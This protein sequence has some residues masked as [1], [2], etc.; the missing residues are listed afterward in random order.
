MIVDV[1]AH[2]RQLAPWLPQLSSAGAH[3]LLLDNTAPNWSNIL[4]N[5]LLLENTAQKWSNILTNI[6]L[7]NT[8]P[9][10]SNIY[11]QYPGFNKTE[12]LCINVITKCDHYIFC[13]PFFFKLFDQRSKQ[14]ILRQAFMAVISDATSAILR[15]QSSIRGHTWGEAY[16]NLRHG[17][18]GW[19][20]D[21]V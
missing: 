16:C 8:A 11:W 21:R 4:T 17:V 18:G 10:W 15:S 6:L 9:Q 19:M 20:C 5:I 1:D 14:Y 7:D 13:W 3:I 12:L 2:G